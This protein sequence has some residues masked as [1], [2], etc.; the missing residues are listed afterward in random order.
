MLVPA[1]STRFERS[2]FSL[3]M[4]EPPASAAVTDS[5][6]FAAEVS[7]G[8]MLTKG[9][10]VFPP[11]ARCVIYCCCSALLSRSCC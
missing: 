7:Q 11:S 1:I 6:I 8:C 9:R 2:A 5:A 3:V 4:S 10:G